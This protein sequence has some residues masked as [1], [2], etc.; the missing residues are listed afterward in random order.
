MSESDRVQ[1]EIIRNMRPEQR[2]A[3][4]IQ[5]NKTMRQL[6]DAGLQMQKPDWSAD[7]RR[8]EIVRRV[9]TAQTS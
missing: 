3:K 1:L 8:Q 2:L 7:Q 9:L 6:M 4:A 5:M